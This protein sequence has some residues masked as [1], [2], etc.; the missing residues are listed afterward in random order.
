MIGSRRWVAILFGG[1]VEVDEDDEDGEEEDEDEEE[2]DD[3]D[4]DDDDDEEEV[5][6]Y[7]RLRP[8]TSSRSSGDEGAL[9]LAIAL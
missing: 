3:D 1:I 9:D 4:D 2:D 6:E 7:F 5:E 8:M